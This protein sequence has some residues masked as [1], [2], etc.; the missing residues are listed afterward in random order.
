MQSQIDKGRRQQQQ[1]V[2]RCVQLVSTMCHIQA[3]APDPVVAC[4]CTA[5]A[6]TPN[7]AKQAVPR[8]RHITK[9][10]FPA[11]FQNSLH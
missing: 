4:E 5:E 11:A 7:V 10:V 9:P 8:H 6:Y 3:F 2:Q 1:E